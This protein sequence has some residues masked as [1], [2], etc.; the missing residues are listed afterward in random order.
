MSEKE[1]RLRRRSKSRAKSENV[2]DSRIAG[3]ETEYDHKMNRR[4]LKS[5]AM[6]HLRGIVLFILLCFV[7]SVSFMVRYDRGP[8][9]YSDVVETK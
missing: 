8:P 4:R 6:G 2:V 9:A 7:A 1:T 3:E 5:V